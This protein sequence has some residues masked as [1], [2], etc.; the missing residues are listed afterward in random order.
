[1]FAVDCLNRGDTTGGTK[2]VST[3]GASLSAPSVRPDIALNDFD[4][5]P[6]VKAEGVVRLFLVRGSSEL[7]LDVPSVSS[8]A[9]AMSAKIPER[10]AD[11]YD[12][13]KG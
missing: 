9:W 6:K 4:G 2:S 12:E 7:D 10:K 13:R 8:D 3:N 5:L 11:P 1:M